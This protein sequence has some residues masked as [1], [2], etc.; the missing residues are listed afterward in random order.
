M[1]S[2]AASSSYYAIR[3]L[4]MA[5]MLIDHIG[6]VF[7][8]DVEMLRAVGRISYPLYAFGV[9]CGWMH[10]HDRQ[11]YIW[12][13]LLVALIAQVFWP[14]LSFGG[15]N[16]VWGFVAVLVCMSWA[17]PR[18]SAMMRTQP[19]AMDVLAVCT[20]WGTLCA[21]TAL[22]GVDYAFETMV[23]V[24]LNCALLWMMRTH[25]RA[26]VWLPSLPSLLYVLLSAAFSD[27]VRPH[28]WVIA[29]LAPVAIAFLH[30]E[31]KVAVAPWFHH[32][33]FLFYPAHLALLY[34]VV[35]A[36]G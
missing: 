11:K 23:Y 25:G 8:P 10:T 26:P 5:T 35:A 4:A 7:W 36:I 16:V 1:K 14:W 27:I 28:L 9:A 17:N 22:V 2:P 21:A 12:L 13:L 20:S 3:T 34:T 24:P 18:I 19:R 15:C 30:K 33:Y 6:A 32:L 31:G 29:L